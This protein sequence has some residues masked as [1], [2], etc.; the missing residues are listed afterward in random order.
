MYKP[1]F[2]SEIPQLFAL[3]V[4]LLATNYLT[5]FSSPCVTL[6]FKAFMCYLLIGIL[7]TLHL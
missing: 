4:Q 6:F 2:E 5:I 3:K 7:V 1:E